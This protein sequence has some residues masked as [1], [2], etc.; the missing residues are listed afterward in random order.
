MKHSS[1]MCAVSHGTIAIVINGMNPVSMQE[2]TC[3]WIVV[4]SSETKQ[5]EKCMSSK[6]YECYK[7]DTTLLTKTGD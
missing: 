4:H 5:Y 1:V 7:N 6:Q 2:Q 3:S